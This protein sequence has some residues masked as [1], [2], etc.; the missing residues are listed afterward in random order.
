LR[1]DH[2]TVFVRWC[3]CASPS[4]ITSSREE[5]GRGK[6]SETRKGGGEVMGRGIGGDA[7]RRCRTVDETC[8]LLINSEHVVTE[9]GC[10]PIAGVGVTC[11]QRCADG[12]IQAA[13]STSRTCTMQL[14]WSGTPPV[15]IAGPSTACCQFAVRKQ[16]SHSSLQQS[17]C[18]LRPRCCYLWSCF[19]RTSFSCRYIRRVTR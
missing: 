12:Y 2:S 16:G 10:P 9:P 4:N 17:C 14:A 19:K 18:R 8:P 5:N 15:C 11:R 1:T 6:R 3:Q 13:G 7:V